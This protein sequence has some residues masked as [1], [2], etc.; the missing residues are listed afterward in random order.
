MSERGLLGC[1]GPNHAVDPIVTKCHP[2]RPG[3]LQVVA[4][5]RAD[6]GGWGLPGAL[7][8]SHPGDGIGAKLKGEFK[9]EKERLTVE[10]DM[11]LFDELTKQLFRGGKIVEK[12][13]VDDNR[14]TD[15]AW[16]ESTVTHFHVE[17]QALANML[18]FNRGTGEDAGDFRCVLPHVAWRD[19][20][21]ASVL[22][23]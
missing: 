16:M 7:V 8:G 1:W 5:K 18:A 20:L 22:A 2:T 11:K 19:G 14:N 6:T 23:S 13:Y 4:M 17:N 9:K 10:A 12:Q 15:N 3:M 21:L